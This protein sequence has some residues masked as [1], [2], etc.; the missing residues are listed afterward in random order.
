MSA[1]KDVIAIEEYHPDN[2]SHKS[3][4]IFIEDEFQDFPEHVIEIENCQVF[5]SKTH[6]STAVISREVPRFVCI[7]LLPRDQ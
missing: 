5:A 1:G 4:G 6:K 2:K 3:D 7:G